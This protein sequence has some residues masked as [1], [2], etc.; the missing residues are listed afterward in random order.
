M[1]FESQISIR[2]KKRKPSKT[3]TR[4]SGIV[5]TVRIS[6]LETVQQSRTADFLR[7]KMGVSVRKWRYQAYFKSMA[8]SPTMYDDPNSTFASLTFKTGLLSILF[9]WQGSTAI[10]WVYIFALHNSENGD[11]C[12]GVK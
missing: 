4:N 3:W 6:F 9:L 2:P 12:T 8:S 1:N 7:Y 10:S 11:A 5:L